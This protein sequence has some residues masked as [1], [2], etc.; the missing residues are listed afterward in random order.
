MIKIHHVP[1]SRSLRVVWL[2][3]EL[4]EPYWLIEVAYPPDAAF[5]AESPLG[6]IPYIEDDD[7][8]R[9]GESIA[10]LQYLT[11]RRIQKALELGLTVGPSPDP[12]AY[13]EHLQLLHLGEA[14]LMTPLGF[15]ARTRRLAPD[16]QDNHTMCVCG[17]MVVRSAEALERKLADGRPWLTGE[18]LT[19][20][21]IS[22]GYGLYFAR[23]RSFDELLPEGVLAYADRVTTRPAFQIALEARIDQR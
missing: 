17:D 4:G 16:Q 13:A 10:I 8:V 22:V 14:S 2:M 18:R 20:A 6:T 3:E 7:G 12:T 11:G 5:R 15:L 19:I 9:M 23:R 21:D 1:H